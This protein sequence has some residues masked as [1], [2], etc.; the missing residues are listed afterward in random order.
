M[1]VDSSIYTAA[2]LIRAIKRLSAYD[3]PSGHMKS[4]VVVPPD[5]RVVLYSD[6]GMILTL[7][8]LFRSFDF[9]IIVPQ[10]GRGFNRVFHSPRRSRRPAAFPERRI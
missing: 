7:L 5:Q 9:F 8:M 4:S 1:N 2:V 6:S 3:E 10:S